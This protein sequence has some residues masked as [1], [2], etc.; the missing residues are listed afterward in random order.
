VIIA[1]LIQVFSPRGNIGCFIGGRVVIGL[2]QGLALSKFFRTLNRT[3]VDQ[4][5]SCWSYLHWRA[6]ST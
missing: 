2:G 4:C 5:N 1:T 6:F 3:P